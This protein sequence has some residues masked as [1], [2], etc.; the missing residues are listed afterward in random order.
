MESFFFIN[1]FSAIFRVDWLSLQLQ[2]SRLDEGL[3]KL[4]PVSYMKTLTFHRAIQ[5]VTGVGLPLVSGA[6]SWN[7]LARD[8]KDFSTGKKLRHQEA[9]QKTVNCATDSGAVKA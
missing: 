8:S 7:Q 1:S 9:H 5:T 2:W 4:Q 3:W 6:H